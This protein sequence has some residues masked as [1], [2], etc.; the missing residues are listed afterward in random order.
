MV[1]TTKLDNGVTIV[2]EEVTYV[3]SVS[4]GLWFK[5]GSR[6]EDARNNGISHFIEHMLF[7]G[8]E[9]R[10]ALQIAQELDFVGGQLNAGTDKEYTCYYARVLSEHLPVA[11][12]VLADMCL[13]SLLDPEELGR[14]RNVV[15]EE[16]KRYQ[17]TPDELVHDL[18]VQ[19]LFPDHP[20]GRPVIGTPETVSALERDDL[21]TYMNRWYQPN[22][23]YVVASGNLKHADV[24]DLFK[25]TL[26]SR[27]GTAESLPSAPLNGSNRDVRYE[28]TTEQVHFC[29]GTRGPDQYDDTKY[30]LAVMD[31]AVGGGMSS[32]LFQEI[33]EKRG[34]AYSVGSYPHSYADTGLYAIYAGTSPDTLDDVLDLCRQEARHVRKEGLNADEFQRAQNQI[35][36][37]LVLSLESMSS[38]MSRM[39]KSQMYFDRVIPMEEVVEKVMS[40]THDDV[41]AVA[42]RVLNEDE[43]SLTVI[44]PEHE[45][46]A[47]A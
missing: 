38:R 12:D 42:D 31:A 36:G 19:N 17:D 28:R 1:E 11:A 13:N 30:A 5:V 21:V 33:R 10:S 34:L 22:R 35:K 6:E 41:K 46:S 37:A 29:I 8:T 45:G 3:Q 39:A 20:I 43:W 4:L 40:V 25:D 16:I 32:R 14:E 44:G 15:L 23:T 2:T 7:K 26:G 27:R 47:E 9:K 18:F 24:V